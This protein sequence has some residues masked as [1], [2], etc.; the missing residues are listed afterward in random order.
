MRT[1]TGLVSALLVAAG[2]A[3]SPAAAADDEG[4]IA[5][6]DPEAMTITLDNG[7]TYKLSVEFDVAALEEGMEVVLAYDTI[8]GQKQVTDLV[9]YE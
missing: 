3:V 2:L 8:A 7:N 4:K 1:A 9:T 6:I 5:A